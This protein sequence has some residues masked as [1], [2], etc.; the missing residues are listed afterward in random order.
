MASELDMMNLLS[1]VRTGDS[2]PFSISQTHPLYIKNKP[3]WDKMCDAFEGQ[4]AIKAKGTT[5][6]PKMNGQT[7]EDYENYK[8]RAVWGDYTRYTIKNYL[9]MLYRK[10]PQIFF[11]E[12]T[13][14]GQK[15]HKGYFET[16]T[17][18]GESLAEFSQDVA[19]EILKTNRVGILVDFP[20]LMNVGNILDL[21]KFDY[22]QKG[23]KPLLSM[24]D[25]FSII[26]WYWEYVDYKLIPRYFVL[27]ETV[28]DGFESG[29]IVS[30]TSNIYRVLFLEEYGDSYRY[31]QIV[32]KEREVK[33]KIVS[34]VVEVI[35]PMMDG[36]SLDFI[37]F[38][39][40]DDKGMNY[41]T[42]ERPMLNGLVDTN[43]G[44]YLNS[45]DWS[46]FLHMLGS[47]TL[48][49]PG[50]DAKIFGQPRV[51]GALAVPKGC[52][53]RMVQ[54]SSDSS[55][56]A[57]MDKQIE[58]M[59]VFGLQRINGNGYIASVDTARVTSSSESS[60]LTIMAKSLGRSFTSIIQFL[61][62]WGQYESDDVLV[63]FNRDFFDDSISGAELLEWIKA[64]QQG[65][66]STETLIYNMRKRELYRD[67]WSLE[68]EIDGI[69]KALDSQFSLAD[70]KF[71]EL[72][73]K[74]DA[75]EENIALTITTS[76]SG[77][78]LLSASTVGG[79]SNISTSTDIS[80]NSLQGAS[81]RNNEVRGASSA[82]AKNDADETVN[83]GGDKPDPDKKPNN[84]ARQVK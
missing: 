8:R 11:G 55:I 61:L 73:Q 80:D 14:E 83:T 48:V 34:D 13:S 77:S 40:L 58:Q 42:I 4:D 81:A 76:S 60:N 3:T 9:G 31:K 68:D 2:V 12:N 82:S 26:N 44:Y 18:E 43:I 22:E 51:G 7:E 49:F 27:K 62:K 64:W 35:E 65:G 50:W 72:K 15:P 21:T 6:L 56:R 29:S 25:A 69:Q 10:A 47:P 67:G 53:P 36:K 57:E 54:A 39:V 78:T 1:M 5:Y 37:P 28:F 52:E 19:E 33:R 23:I 75:L 84:D 20:K 45:A 41:K 59:A 17:N 63:E 30:S 79:G 32:F 38:Y 71:I 16:I 74:F 70:E 46:N 24:Y 66:I